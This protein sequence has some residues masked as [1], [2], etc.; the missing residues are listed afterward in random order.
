MDDASD[1]LPGVMRVV[2]GH[3]TETYADLIDVGDLDRR[4]PQVRDLSFLSRALAAQAVRILTECSAPEAAAAVTDGEGDHGIDAIAVSPNGSDIWFVQAKWSDRGRAVLGEDG[5]LKLVAGLRRLA[6]RH[7]DGVNVK[8]NRQLTRIDEALSS[9]RCTVHL[10]AALAGGGQVTYQAEQR[11]TRVGQEFGFDGRTPVKVHT[12]GLAD[13]HTFARLHAAPGPV[14]ITAT[15]TQGWHTVHTPYLAFAGSVPAGEAAAWFEAHGPHLLAPAL[16]NTR[17]DRIDQAIVEQLVEEP[18]NFWYY[19]NGVTLMCD[20]VQAQFFGRRLQGEPARLEL[21]NA[22][23]INGA[24][25][26]AAVAHAVAQHPATAE[27]ALVPL[28]V[29][30][31]DSAPEGF[32]SQL[33]ATPQSDSHT[34]LLDQVAADPQQL[35]IREEFAAELGKQYVFKRGAPPPAPSA[36]CT[37]QEAALA[38]ACAHRDVSL[39]AHT[40]AG[41]EHLFRPSPAGAYNR[42]FGQ[43]PPGRQI[44]AVV[45]AHRLVQDALADIAR[46][47]SPW[48]REVMDHGDLLISHLAFQSIGLED[49]E[50]WVHNAQQD[51]DWA[52]QWTADIVRS[53]AA[54]VT[55]RYGQSVFLAS[56]FTDASKCRVL[57]EIVSRASATG[58]Q[59]STANTVAPARRRRNSISVLVDHGRIPDGTRLLYRPGSPPEEAAIGD[60]LHENPRRYLATWVNDRQRPLI[61]E[62]DQQA[63]SPTGLIMH[64]W[65]EAGWGEAPVAVQG[66]ARWFLPGEGTLADL[67]GELVRAAALDGGA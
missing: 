60:W 14:Q 40:S 37:V 46:T 15:L 1:D 25:T 63:Y 64:I 33:S 53:L 26:L 35:R 39:S 20:S 61:W 67:A 2:R 6:N 21:G 49:T 66:P 29:I 8:I 38:L 4:P 28:R 10:V 30:C 5:A 31:V 23:L 41:L 51:P 11:L 3:L 47:E 24:R 45:Q 7:Y 58:N 50:D 54:A 57:A 48:R 17:S 22:R 19:S 56:V 9:P 27:Q 42:L 12:L 55:D 43:A 62:A 34:D 36:G 13:F 59:E 44:W 16:R 65:R 18:E 32:L 52:K